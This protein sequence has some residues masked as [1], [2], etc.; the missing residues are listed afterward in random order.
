M[1][2]VI[3]AILTE[4]SHFEILVTQDLS[5][6]SNIRGPGLP[7]NE[8]DSFGFGVSEFPKNE[9]PKDSFVNRKPRFVISGKVKP[10]FV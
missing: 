7:M 5:C 8:K 1:Y 9:S 4:I 2:K 10:R 6:F 3:C